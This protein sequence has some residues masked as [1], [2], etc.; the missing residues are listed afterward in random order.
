MIWLVVGLLPVSSV[1]NS[2]L[3]TIDV[4]WQERPPDLP[5]LTKMYG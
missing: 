4:V 5:G 1:S 2:T 3:S